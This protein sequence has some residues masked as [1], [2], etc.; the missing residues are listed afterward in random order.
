MSERIRY[1]IKIRSAD[2]AVN[3]S[4]GVKRF[5]PDIRIVRQY[6]RF[7]LKFVEHAIRCPVIVHG[8]VGPNVDEI[9]LGASRANDAHPV[10]PVKT[11]TLPPL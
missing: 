6:C 4:C 9:L 5:A 7:P 3:S 8:D 2:Q 10:T 11:G 1:K